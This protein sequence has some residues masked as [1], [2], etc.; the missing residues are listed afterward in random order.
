MVIRLGTVIYSKKVTVEN[1]PIMLC[2]ECDRSEVLPNVKPELRDLLHNLGDNPQKQ[3]IF[4]HESNEL[5]LLLHE[6]L[7]T[8]KDDLSIESIA[9][10]RVN[11]L[12]DLLLLAQ[13]LQDT[14]WIQELRHR[15]SQISQERWVDLDLP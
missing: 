11:Q 9:R 8:K 5:A 10:D 1:V 14:T 2:E 6:A 4:F 7:L 13:S 15:L 3:Q 12:L